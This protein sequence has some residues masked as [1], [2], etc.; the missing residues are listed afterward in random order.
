MSMHSWSYEFLNNI[1]N[2]LRFRIDDSWKGPSEHRSQ[3]AEVVKRL[4]LGSVSRSAFDLRRVLASIVCAWGL[5]R[6]TKS[7]EN[8]SIAHIS[9]QTRSNVCSET[10]YNHGII[11]KNKIYKNRVLFRCENL[12]IMRFRINILSTACLIIRF[13]YGKIEI[14]F[15]QKINNKK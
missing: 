6:L 9:S 13:S 4:L 8:F 11:G 10:S 5:F 3:R 7:N 2:H 12:Q 14:D 15:M 1:S